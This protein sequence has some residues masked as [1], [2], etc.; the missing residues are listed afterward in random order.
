MCELCDYCEYERRPMGQKSTD[1]VWYVEIQTKYDAPSKSSQFKHQIPIASES[2]IGY[3]SNCFLFL[4]SMIELN[5][6]KPK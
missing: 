3:F 5:M 1:T 6:E 2:S 4:I